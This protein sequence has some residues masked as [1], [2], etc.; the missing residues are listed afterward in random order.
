[1]QIF[2]LDHRLAPSLV[3][4]CSPQIP[5][6]PSLITSVSFESTPHNDWQ[7]STRQ[8]S[9]RQFSTR[10]S[11]TRQFSKRQSPPQPEL[12]WKIPAVLL[13]SRLV[14]QA[15]LRQRFIQQ[16]PKHRECVPTSPPGRVRD[17]STNEWTSDLQGVSSEKNKRG[18]VGINVGF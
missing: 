5:F 11:S 10:Q 4:V 16:K 8:F 1:M 3:S 15:L 18:N 9:T 6:F 14:L 7:F 13:E 17:A 12:L 2:Y